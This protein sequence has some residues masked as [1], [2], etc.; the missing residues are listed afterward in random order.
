MT[1]T[2]TIYRETFADDDTVT[3]EFEIEIEATYH[4]GESATYWQPEDPSRIE[5]DSATIDGEEVDLTDAEEDW[6]IEKLYRDMD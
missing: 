1:M 3:G 6:A 2:T 4:K 5:I